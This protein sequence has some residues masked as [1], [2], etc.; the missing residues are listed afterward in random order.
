MCMLTNQAWARTATRDIVCYKIVNRYEHPFV[1]AS[2]VYNF[3]YELGKEYTE[4]S[5]K[6]VSHSSVLATLKNEV[7]I[8]FHSYKRYRDAKA[9][10][11]NH[12]RVVMKCIIPKG[13]LYFEGTNGIEGYCSEKIRVVGYQDEGKRG[14]ITES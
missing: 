14:W 11:F 9:V 3:S 1:L 6:S 2:E 5:F 4:I 8:G 10:K 12:R 7:S 13:S